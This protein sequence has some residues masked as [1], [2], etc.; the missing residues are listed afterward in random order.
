MTCDLYQ[1]CFSI[2][3]RNT[4]AIVLGMVAFGLALSIGVRINKIPT[5]VDWQTITTLSGLL[6][7]TAGIKESGLFYF[8]ACRISRRIDS[9]RL[10]AL[11]L[12]FLSAVL[13]MFMTN[14]IALFIMVPLTLSLQEIS[15]NDYSKLIIFEAIAVNVGSALTPIGNPQNIFLWH[16]WGIS[17]SVF[18]REMAPLVL[19]MSTILLVMTLLCFASRKIKVSIRDPIIVDRKLFALSSFALVA[20]TVAVELQYEQ[21]ALPVI[22]LTFLLFYKKILVKTDWGIIILF[23]VVFINM[24]LILEFQAMQHMLALFDFGNVRTLFLTGAFFSQAISNVPSAIL[25][26]NYSIDFKTIAYGVTI[27]GNGLLIGSFANL[28]ALR[29]TQKPVNYLVFHY[30]SLPYYL[31]TLAVT[32]YFLIP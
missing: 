7:V 9:E 27:G 21:Y 32:Y 24:N 4:L 6:I 29:F 17:F 2:L 18:V 10:L 19:L 15:G 14:D 30:Y 5:L 25:L 31:L 22:F 23:I 26:T 13:S 28:I 8:L 11:F 16:Q 1:A 3:K 12:V 20:F